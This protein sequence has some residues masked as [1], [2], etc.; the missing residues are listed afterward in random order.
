MTQKGVSRGAADLAIYDPADTE[1]GRLVGRVVA[2]EPNGTW[3]IAPDYL[4]QA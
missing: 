1:A 4:D 2:R 3:I